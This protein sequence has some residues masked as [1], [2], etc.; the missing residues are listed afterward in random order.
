MVHVNVTLTCC[1]YLSSIL[2]PYRVL[3]I[4]KVNI[5]IC[6]KCNL[7]QFYFIIFTQM[8]FPCGALLHLTTIIGWMVKTHFPFLKLIWNG[9]IGMFLTLTLSRLQ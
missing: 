3:H 7:I 9:D 2:I 6:S 5:L 8:V 4:T 1:I